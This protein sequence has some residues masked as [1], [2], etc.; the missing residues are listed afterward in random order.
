[1]AI[2]LNTKFAAPF[3]NDDEYCAISSQVT[4][5]HEL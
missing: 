1:M 3:I 4:A 2:K 5:A